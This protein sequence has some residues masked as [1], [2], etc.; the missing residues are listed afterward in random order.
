[1]SIKNV[2]EVFLKY[3]NHPEFLGVELLDANQQGAVDDTLLHI[4]A[5]MGEALADTMPLAK[6]CYRLNIGE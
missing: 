1:M 2:T 4:A 5:R 6:R 3:K